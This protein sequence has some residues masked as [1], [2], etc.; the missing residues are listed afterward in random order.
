MKLMIL[1]ALGSNLSGPWGTPQQTLRR[2]VDEIGGD[3]LQ[4][5][6]VSC[7]YRTR[8]YGVAGQPD[9]LNAVIQIAGFLPPEALLGRLHR[10]ERAAA[11][12]RGGRWGV[13][14]LD[15]DLL[16]WNGR[17]CGPRAENS[18]LGQSGF[19]PMSLPHPGIENRPFVIIPLAEIV[20][21]WHHPVTGDLAATLARGAK[22]IFAGAVLDKAEL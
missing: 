10:I 16:D 4:V 5:V 8:A 3:A 22:R 1:I 20:P 15:I 17:I 19:K 14:T 13:R 11:R 2:A 18:R 7:A 12:A 9:Y 21:S 6:A